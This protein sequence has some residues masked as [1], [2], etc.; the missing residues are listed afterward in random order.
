[1]QIKAQNM[2]SGVLSRFKCMWKT[3]LLVTILL[4]SR[5]AKHVTIKYI[6]FAT[7]GSDYDA[8]APAPFNA[9]P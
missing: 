3:V 1:V 7:N 9:G 6:K 4:M 2:T 8:G 5:L